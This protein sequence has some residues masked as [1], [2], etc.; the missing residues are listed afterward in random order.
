MKEYYYNKEFIDIL[1]KY[2]NE[3]DLHSFYKLNNNTKYTV[4]YITSI[5]KAISTNYVNNSHKYTFP[6]NLINYLNLSQ[7]SLYAKRSIVGFIKKQII[8]INNDNNNNFL[9]TY[10]VIGHDYPI[11]IKE[12]TVI[13]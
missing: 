10:V 6:I 8:N 5:V 13:I 12:L 1:I 7:Y 9:K 11:V 4:G 2:L 3:K